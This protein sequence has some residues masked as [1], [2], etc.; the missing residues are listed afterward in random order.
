MTDE[1]RKEI[2]LY[3]IDRA[4]NTLKEVDIHVTNGL[5]NTAINRM[6]YACFYAVSSLLLYHKINAQSHAGV[7]KMFGLHFI[8][9]QVIPN[10]LG[11]FYS[12]IFTLR[13][14]DDYDDF[15]EFNEEDVKTNLELAK[16]LIF[17]IEEMVNNEE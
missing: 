8:K 1:E 5:W 2:V 16:V 11:K 3:R 17:K 9:S 7:R 6:Y 10:E 4:K 13:H 14:M 12:N 15:I